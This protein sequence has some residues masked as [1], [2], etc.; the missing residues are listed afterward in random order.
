MEKGEKGMD[1]PQREQALVQ[2]CMGS[3]AQS[4]KGFIQTWQI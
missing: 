4:G 2:V 1:L 3:E